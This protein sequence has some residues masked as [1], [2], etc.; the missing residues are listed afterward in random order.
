MQVAMLSRCA[1]GL[2]AQSAVTLELRHWP[3][4]PRSSERFK[5]C[6]STI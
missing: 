6:Q 4:I 2:A 3:C 5:E 1:S